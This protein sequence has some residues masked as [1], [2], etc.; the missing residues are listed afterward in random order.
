MLDGVPYSERSGPASSSVMLD[1]S[2]LPFDS[3]V[4]FQ[5]RSTRGDAVSSMAS[6]VLHTV[7]EP[8]DQIGNPPLIGS[9]VEWAPRGASSYI[10]FVQT[11]QGLF[12]SP[13][14]TSTSYWVVNL[15]PYDSNYTAW[16][17]S[18]NAEGER[19]LFISNVLSS[20][21][22]DGPL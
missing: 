4:E 11:S 18:V 9:I 5:V 7:A 10:V 15:I 16:V 21:A 17:V 1:F 22:F 14:I 3:R 20:R 6:A 19:S 2:D 8:V 13:Q 12:E